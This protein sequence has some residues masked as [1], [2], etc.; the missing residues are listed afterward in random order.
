MV[1]GLLDDDPSARGRSAEFLES[2]HPCPSLTWR[3]GANH[4]A[5]VASTEPRALLSD[6]DFSS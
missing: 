3:L 1:E 5:S 2:A 6:G 4:S